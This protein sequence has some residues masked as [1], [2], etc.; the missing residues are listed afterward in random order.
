MAIGYSMSG[1]QAYHWGALYPDLVERICC[2][3]GSAKTTPHNWVYLNGYKTIMECAEGWDDGNCATWPPKLL[4][5]ITALATTMAWSQDWYRASGFELMGAADLEGFLSTAEGFFAPWVPANLYHQTL[6]W[7]AA[8]VSAHPKFN[9]DLGKALGSI[10]CPAL[11]MPCDTDMYFRVADNEREVA[12]MPNAELKV[13]HSMWGH[14][15]GMPGVSATD[16][17]FI[18]DAVKELL[19]R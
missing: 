11:I 7:M 1:Q 10:T 5:A 16:D 15:A 17:A 18:D 2:N 14:L 19:P 9:G 13:I 6:T 3:C 8:D 12:Q 4:T